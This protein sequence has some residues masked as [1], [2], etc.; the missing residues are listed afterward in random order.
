MD[1]RGPA[2]GQ[3][4]PMA[5]GMQGPV[6]HNMGPNAPPPARPVTAA[7]DPT[8]FC[9]STWLG[10]HVFSHRLWDSSFPLVLFIWKTRVP[11]THTHTHCMQKKNTIRE[12]SII[13]S[14][15]VIIS[16]IPN[17]EVLMPCLSFRVLVFLHREEASVQ[18][19]ARFPHRTRRRW[20]SLYHSCINM[21]WEIFS[22][23]D[24]QGNL[25]RSS[26]GCQVKAN[27]ELIIAPLLRIDSVL[28]A[29]A[30]C[31]CTFW[32]NPPQ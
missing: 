6:P 23:T 30:M 2:S 27:T 26:V 9:P 10:F 1:A 20:V 25:Q 24:L 3:R 32:Y 21:N 22:L 18:G 15:W 19:R 5:G 28:L 29:V 4:V 11:Q 16:S 12:I 14:D 8:F 31:S 7:S 17:K 13:C